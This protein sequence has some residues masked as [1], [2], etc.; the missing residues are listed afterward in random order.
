LSND[1]FPEGHIGDPIG[2]TA[3]I[4]ASMFESAV[5]GLCDAMRE[6]SRFDF[7]R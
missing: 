6:I 3:E 1:F 7:G 5:A 2:A 4:G